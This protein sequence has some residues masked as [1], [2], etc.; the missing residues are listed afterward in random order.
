VIDNRA[1]CKVNDPQIHAVKSWLA[2]GRVD[3]AGARTHPHSLRDF[4]VRADRASV[5][6]SSC[7]AAATAPIEVELGNLRE[8][9]A[10]SDA[11]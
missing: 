1:G 11:L 4:T 3:G 9:G 8:G 7:E 2:A 6:R 10:F 5:C